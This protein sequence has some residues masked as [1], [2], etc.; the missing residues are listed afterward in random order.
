MKD[1]RNHHGTVGK[2]LKHVIKETG[3]KV[4]CLAGFCHCLVMTT[5]AYV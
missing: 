3:S 5:S 2:S 1:K 4:G